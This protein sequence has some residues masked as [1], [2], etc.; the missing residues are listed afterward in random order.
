MN[1]YLITVFATDE[2]INVPNYLST[3]KVAYSCIDVTN[4]EW[5]PRSL[6]EKT[7]ARYLVDADDATEAVAE[8]LLSEGNENERVELLPW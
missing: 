3:F 2:R 4:V 5:E 7:L 6:T 8:A 1:K